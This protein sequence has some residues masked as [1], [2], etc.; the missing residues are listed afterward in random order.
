MKTKGINKVAT[1]LGLV[2]FLTG[3]IGT[4]GSWG[5]YW[6]DSNI[7]KEGY[8]A[9]GHITKKS[10][11]FVADGRSDYVLD[12]WFQLPDGQRVVA[13]RIVHKALWESVR[14]DT[15][16]VVLYAV[17][18][19]NSNFPQGGGVSSI[20]LPLFVSVLFFVL[21]AFGALLTISAVRTPRADS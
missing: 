6:R 12:Y 5:A 10:I 7:V 18:N 13:H 11:A 8:S 1:V 9:T 20:A 17:D 15:P 19:P 2:L 3:C 16:F 14:E 21:G 4:V